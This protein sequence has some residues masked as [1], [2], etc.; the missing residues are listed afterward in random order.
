LILFDRIVPVLMDES[1]SGIPVPL[2]FQNKMSSGNAL[3]CIFCLL[4]MVIFGKILMG[5]ERLFVLSDDAI[6]QLVLV[7]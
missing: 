2:Q 6:S 7:G 5:W 4:Q 3:K 1:K